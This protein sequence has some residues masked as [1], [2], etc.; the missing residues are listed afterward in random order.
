MARKS[1]A[2]FLPSLNCFF[3]GHRELERD[4]AYQFQQPVLLLQPRKFRP[5]RCTGWSFGHRHRHRRSLSRKTTVLSPAGAS[6]LCQS[7]MP[8]ARGSTSAAS[9]F[10]ARQ[11][12]K[13]PAPM[14]LT[15]LPAI[16]FCSIGIVKSR[17]SLSN[18]SNR[19]SSSVRSV[20]R[21][22]ADSCNVFCRSSRSG[23]HAR[24]LLL[25]S[26]KTRKPRSPANSGW[27]SRIF[28]PARLLGVLSS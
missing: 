19:M 26:L 21:C 13:V 9:I 4:L 11:T 15:A 27:A 14:L 20:F 6:C 18:N 3:A 2:L 22:S 12:I 16:A 1:A 23:S 28:L 5:G 7:A 17:P 24:M 8:S 10:G 25:A